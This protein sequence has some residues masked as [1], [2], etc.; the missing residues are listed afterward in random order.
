M[1][2]I[3]KPEGKDKFPALAALMGGWFHQDYD[4][5]GE[6]LPEVI[7]A[8]TAETPEELVLKVND[9]ITSFLSERPDDAQLDQDFQ[10]MFWPCVIP[11][12]WEPGITN[13]RQ[14]LTRVAEL[15][16]KTPQSQK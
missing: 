4:I 5:E 6:T 14:W 10:R 1:G 12:G 8:F 9:D 15:L 16:T 13:W 7:G 2:K 3:I 11:E